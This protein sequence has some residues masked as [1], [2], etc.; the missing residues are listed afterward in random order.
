[1]VLMHS[2]ASTA[3]APVKTPSS[4]ALEAVDN[5]KGPKASAANVVAVALWRTEIESFAKH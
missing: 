5:P 1:M 3:Y 2:E 4:G